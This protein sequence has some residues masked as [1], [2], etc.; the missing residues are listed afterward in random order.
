MLIL[1]LSHSHKKHNKVDYYKLNGCIDIFLHANERSIETEEGIQ[2]VAE[3]VYLR[4]YENK[5]KKEIE[6]N[7]NYYWQL[8]LN[9][10]LTQDDYLLDLEFRISLLEL[11]L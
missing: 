1:N 6:N 2:Y 11:G 9:K 4:L 3:E 10:E 7:F 8:G 5:E